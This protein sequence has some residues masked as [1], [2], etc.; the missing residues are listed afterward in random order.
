L[1][2]PIFGHIHWIHA[3]HGRFCYIPIVIAAAWFGL[4]GALLTALFI[5]V[6]ILPYILGSNL[7]SLALVDEFTEIVFYFAVAM[8]A[9][10]LVQREF[11]SRQKAEDMRLQLERSQKMSLV[12]QIAAGMAHEIKN[13][14]A[15]IKGAVEI[16]CDDENSEQDRDEFKTIVL[17]EVKRI[18]ASV[19]DFLEFARPSETRMSE[20]NLAEI[21]RASI[22]Q[23]QPQAGERNISLDSTLQDPVPVKGDG[24][25]IH[26]VL[27]NLLLNAVDASADASAVTVTLSTD[28]ERAMIAV[29]DSG[30]GIGES[31]I[32]RVFEPFFTTKSSGTGL[33]LAIAKNI[34]GTHQGT[35]TLRNLPDRGA[36]AEISLPL[37]QSG[38]EA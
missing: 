26:Q 19:S 29:E 33:G 18:N 22:R 25:K 11:R 6:A 3:I 12:G 21:V 30:D 13:P 24:E 32:A 27:L 1:I 37:Y 5:S 14:L 2:E 31:D 4:R 34:I 10:G 35:I 36:V 9:G 8:L 7:E 38:A 15:S 23:V 16:L 20:L 17:K 28:D